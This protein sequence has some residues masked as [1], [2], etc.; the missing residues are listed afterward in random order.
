MKLACLFN[1]IEHMRVVNVLA[2]N[3]PTEKSPSSVKVF[4][5]AKS[6]IIFKL[7]FG[8]ELNRNLLIKFLMAVLNLPLDEYTDIQI[9]DPQIK[10]KY[11][12]DKL[13]ILDV[14]VTT[15]TGKV[16]N[17]E[18]QVHVTSEMRERI[19]FYNAKMMSEQLGSGDDYDSIK[20]TINIVITGEIFIYE[21]DKYHDKF[22]IYSAETKTQFSDIVEI[23]TLELPKLP[24][25]SDGTDLC[26]WLE[27]I[28]AD[29][30]KELKMLAQRSPQMKDPVDKLLEL[31]QDADARALFEAR[32]KQRR[33]NRA[34]NKEM[35]RRATQE[36]MEKGWQK[37]MQKGIQEGRQ[38]GIQEGRQEGRQEGVFDVAKNLLEMNM[39]VEDIAK[40][41]GLAIEEIKG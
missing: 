41:T 7:L 32:E 24:K 30:E 2:D 3:K 36:A 33:D 1:I 27:F 19:V 34:I 10:R 25:V 13:S 6:D 23:H 8:N 4:M 35:I 38:K 17:I 22:T 31:N 40:A 18:I 39:P 20:K 29:S 14:K 9:S 11:K 15:T 5:S 21:H 26:D 28:N 16:I 37:G 12:G